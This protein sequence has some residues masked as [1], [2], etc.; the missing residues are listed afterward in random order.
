MRGNKAAEGDRGNPDGRAGTELAQVPTQ[1][2]PVTF[3]DRLR[4]ASVGTM[5]HPLIPSSFLKEG[6]GHRTQPQSLPWEVCGTDV[7]RSTGHPR[8]RAGPAREEGHCP[9]RGDAVAPHSPVL[10]W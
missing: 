6:L 4:S 3:A 7:K 2:S 9:A 1:S 10:R 8:G 5:A